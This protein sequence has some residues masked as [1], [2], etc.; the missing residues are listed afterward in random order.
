MINAKDS[1]PGGRVSRRVFLHAS[2]VIPAALASSELL[3]ASSAS[4]TPAVLPSLAA[5]EACDSSLPLV[6]H[7][8]LQPL[9]AQVT[10][11][12]TAAEYLGTGRYRAPGA[13]FSRS[14]LTPPLTS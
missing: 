1:L 7:V 2:T 14:P 11:L 10:R 4:S 6:G 5:A 12:I 13:S 9:V 8:P 3:G